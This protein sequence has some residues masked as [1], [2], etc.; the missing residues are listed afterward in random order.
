MARQD[1]F[2]IIDGLFHADLPVAF[3]QLTDDNFGVNDTVYRTADGQKIVTVQSPQ[4]LDL[5]DYR[6]YYH[7]RKIQVQ[8][9]KAEWSEESLMTVFMAEQLRELYENQKKFWIQYDDEMSRCWGRCVGLNVDLKDGNAPHVYFTPHYPIFP[10]GHEPPDDPNLATAWDDMLM[11]GRTVW[12]SGTYNV[13]PD[14]GMVVIDA[15]G[16]RYSDRVKAHL[17]YTWRG[18]VRIRELQLV[19]FKMAQ[20]YY[21]GLVVFEQIAVPINGVELGWRD[22][23]YTGICTYYARVR[24]ST[25][26]KIAITATASGIRYAHR[27]T[28]GSINGNVVITSKIIGGKNSVAYKYGRTPVSPIRF[29]V[30]GAGV[31]NYQVV[32]SGVGTSRTKSDSG[33]G[34]AR[35]TSS[36]TA[37][38]ILADNDADTYI[39]GSTYSQQFKLEEFADPLVNTGHILKVTWRRVT[40]VNTTLTVRLLQ[41]SLLIAAP[42]FTQSTDG[43]VVST[44]T[45]TGAQADLI[46]DYS[47]LYIEFY[48]DYQAAILTFLMEMP[49]PGANIKTRSVTGNITV[50]STVKARR[51]TITG[52]PVLGQLVIKC[53]PNNGTTA[54]VLDFSGNS[55]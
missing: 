51:P 52:Y 39:Y 23:P 37:S 14:Y 26:A 10:Y 25:R 11:V 17:K 7:R 38:Q 19:P 20:T 13:H 29:I 42:T 30:S 1:G 4:L 21:T 55:D 40:T 5:G 18:Y 9:W 22:P 2:F 48:A 41:G 46:T 16:R 54:Q 6:D 49:L 3:N 36:K 31:I 50:R 35:S 34:W 32:S 44:Y 12:A 28:S 47:N 24:T 27:V 15:G 45:L 43:D 53:S 33:V 8:A